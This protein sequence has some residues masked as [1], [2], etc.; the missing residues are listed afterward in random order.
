MALV[1]RI[2][3]LVFVAVYANAQ[4]PVLKSKDEIELQS[5]F[6]DAMQD[7][8]LEKYDEALDRFKKLRPKVKNEGIVE[9]EMAKIYD[10]QNQ[11]DEAIYFAEKAVE[12]DT[13]KLIYAQ[14]L[15]DLYKKNKDYEKAA[16]LM[17]AGLEKGYFDSEKYYQ[18]ADY[19]FKANKIDKSLDILDKLAK[20]T[21]DAKGVGLYKSQLLLRNHEYKKALKLVDKLLRK[22][23]SDIK[24]LLRKGLILRL[25]NKDDEAL[26]IYRKIL[27][28]D[29]SNPQALSYMTAMKKFDQSEAEYVDNLLPLIQNKEVDFDK[30]IKML[31]PFVDKVSENSNLSR[32]MLAIAGE[33]LKLYPGKAEANA[34]YADILNNSGRVD[35]S[36][37]YY[38]KTLQLNKSNFDIWKQLMSLYT[39]RR[40]WKNLL[41]VSEEAIEYYPNQALGYYYAARALVNLGKPDEALQYL[42]D[43]SD[44]ATK[45]PRLQNEIK[46]LKAKCYISKKKISQARQILDN[47][48]TAFSNTHPWYWELKG[49]LEMLAGNKREALQYWNKSKELGNNTQELAEKI[50]SVQR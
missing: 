19:Y 10:N 24:L 27:T 18:A 21:G 34:L 26:E 33:L 5:Q 23:P 4:D 32:S 9:Y 29:P 47:I 20:L 7:M 39:M 40:D 30:K 44:Y 43:A 31:I 12:K 42:E 41:R 37:K 3:L 1:Y 48:D 8:V 15:I 17:E 13:S 22:Y 38:E 35:E 50:K 14:F 2:V 28:L 49:D 11:M 25:M 36:I 46:L 45:N 6:I 16:R